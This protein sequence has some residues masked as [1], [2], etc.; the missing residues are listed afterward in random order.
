M[1]L[2]LAC[3]QWPLGLWNAFTIRIFTPRKMFQ[4]FSVLSFLHDYQRKSA[5]GFDF[6]TFQ[7][8]STF[9]LPKCG[10]PPLFSPPVTV[11]F[12]LRQCRQTA[13]PPFCR[14]LGP[15]CPLST[16][17]FV[18]P[19]PPTEKSVPGF[20]FPVRG[21][22]RACPRLNSAEGFDFLNPSATSTLIF[23]Y[24]INQAEGLKH[25]SRGTNYV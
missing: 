18:L 23:K 9:S 4:P 15:R 3:R 11:L 5:E 13:C 7:H 16:P 21:L 2:D 22:V 17:P 1:E 24:I 12:A 25:F 19:T 20:R 14:P 6:Q 10:L 8:C